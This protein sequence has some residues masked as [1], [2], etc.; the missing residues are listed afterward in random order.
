MDAG[1][2]D[3]NARQA[4]KFPPGLGPFPGFDP[5]SPTPQ[6]NAQPEQG[7]KERPPGSKLYSIAPF[8]PPHQIINMEDCLYYDSSSHGDSDLSSN[9]DADTAAERAARAKNEYMLNGQDYRA[10]H[11]RWFDM[12]TSTAYLEPLSPH[13]FKGFAN[14]TCP[15]TPSV[16]S[17]G[18]DEDFLEEIRRSP[19]ACK[20]EHGVPIVF[21]DVCWRNW[22][23]DTAMVAET[24]ALKLS[25]ETVKEISSHTLWK[26]ECMAANTAASAKDRSEC[27]HL[28]EV[29][30]SAVWYPETG[31]RMGISYCRLSRKDIDGSG[32]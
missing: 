22:S 21:D 18:F 10:T 20:D 25:A 31:L 13:P 32:A 6:E 14:R 8:T 27:D 11:L 7:I 28:G 12:E 9:G 2:V 15:N 23:F 16:R 5:I 29:S 3:V 24:S 19:T 26:P 30:G 4:P 1:P 17:D